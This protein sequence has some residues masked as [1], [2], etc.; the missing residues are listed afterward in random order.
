MS[1]RSELQLKNEK[2]EEIPTV[3]A[4]VIDHAKK[5]REALKSGKALC[6]DC[7]GIFVSKHGLKVH[8]YHCKGK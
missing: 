7:L 2:I 6:D 5:I 8:Q 3:P 4:E 1:R